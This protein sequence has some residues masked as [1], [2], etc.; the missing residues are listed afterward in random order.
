MANPTAIKMQLDMTKS[1]D[2][3]GA[4]REFWMRFP[5]LRGSSDQ[6]AGANDGIYYIE[7]PYYKDMVILD[8]LCVITTQTANDGDIDVGFA[9][10]AT[11]TASLSHSNIIFDSI[12]NT[13]AGVFEG[14]TPQA[15]AGT[16]QKYIW[17]AK[18][19]STD[20]FLYVIQNGD[21][22]CSALRWNLFLKVI[23]YNDLLNDNIDL[24]AITV[25]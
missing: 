6:D 5:G 23:P 11:G 12:V 20:S 17:K 4:C 24:G 14:T 19:S 15:L 7:N 25:S 16:G 1:S 18:G 8:A 3:A 22:D 2:Q 13:A 9:D 21:V 10:N